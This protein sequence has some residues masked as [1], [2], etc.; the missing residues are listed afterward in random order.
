M[1]TPVCTSVLGETNMGANL[2]IPAIEGG[3]N[4]SMSGK[5]GGILGQNIKD[6]AIGAFTGKLGVPPEN[7]QKGIT[8]NGVSYQ[9]P[10]IASQDHETGKNASSYS[11]GGR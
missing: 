1:D 7:Q 11:V 2:E 3:L 5:D 10:N 4:Q 8:E 6:T 9:G